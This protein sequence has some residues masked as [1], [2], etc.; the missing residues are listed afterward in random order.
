MKG[1][2]RLREPEEERVRVLLAGKFY[3]VARSLRPVVADANLSIVM[4]AHVKGYN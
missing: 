4:L 3:K 2:R 1:E